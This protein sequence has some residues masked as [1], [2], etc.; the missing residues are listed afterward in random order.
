MIALFSL[1]LFLADVADVKA[2][3][4]DNVHR[5]ISSLIK[6]SPS[7]IK[8]L[9]RDVIRAFARNGHPVVSIGRNREAI[10][11]DDYST[12]LEKVARALNETEIAIPE[13]IVIDKV[14]DIRFIPARGRQWIGVRPYMEF[15]LPHES[16]SIFTIL[17][18]PSFIPEEDIV[19]GI[20]VTLLERNIK[21]SFFRYLGVGI[22]LYR[23]LISKEKGLPLED[24]RR[25]LEKISLIVSS[26]LPE[27]SAHPEYPRAFK[28]KFRKLTIKVVGPNRTWEF[29]FAHN[30]HRLYLFVPSSVEFSAQSVD[31]MMR[32]L[33]EATSSP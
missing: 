33:S 31:N 18:I 14:A 2:G 27:I 32:L 28:E 10:S 30:E 16:R 21:V 23:S 24:Y 6:G 29:A 12:I 20:A 25:A 1:V 8:S 13:G 3:V 4:C 7:P 15:M 17:T 11:D 9:E 22:N 19:P 5:L 26:S